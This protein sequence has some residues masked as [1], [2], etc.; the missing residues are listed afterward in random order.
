M[1]K[2]KIF[3]NPIKEE[4]WINAQLEKGYQLIAHSSWGICTFR[5]TEKKYVT[6]IDYR[7]LNKKQYD[8][9]IAL[10]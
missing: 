6:R 8:E 7:S 5:K 2:F 10:H 1:R 4:A 3:M 9:Y